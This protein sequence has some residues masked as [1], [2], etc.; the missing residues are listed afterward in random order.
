[1]YCDGKGGRDSS[2]GIA[3]RYWLDCPR[4]ESR[5]EARFSA[6]VQ[7]GPGAHPAS[8]TMGT[9]SFLEVKRPGRGVVHPPTSSANVEGSVELFICSPSRPSWP[10]I[11]T[12]L[13]LRLPSPLPLHFTFFDGVF[14]AIS[15]K[16]KWIHRIR[17]N[18]TRMHGKELEISGIQNVKSKCKQNWINHLER[19]DNTS[20][21][22]HA[23]KCKPQRRRDRG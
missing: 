11:G 20:L 13:P 12:A 2:I 17:Q 21:P 18:K 5:W 15:K 3:T 8:Y 4:I 19:M 1:M 23:L 10:V 9:G 6:P 7:T 16:C 14:D 22:K